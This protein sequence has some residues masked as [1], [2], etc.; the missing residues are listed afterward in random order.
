[1]Q[2]WLLVHTDGLR[3]K[4][5]L[6]RWVGRGIKYARSIPR[7]ALESAASEDGT[8]AAGHSILFADGANG[9]GSGHSRASA[10]SSCPVVW[11]SEAC[12]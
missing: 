7:K 9:Q 11:R 10:P 2:G 8:L 1:M 12:P 6:E 5:Q 3:T 4:R